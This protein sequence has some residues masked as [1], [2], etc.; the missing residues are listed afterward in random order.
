MRRRASKY[1]V[2]TAETDFPKGCD[3]AG[4]GLEERSRFFT[5]I[6]HI[7]PDMVYPPEECLPFFKPFARR[8]RDSRPPHV[9]I[10]TDRMFRSRIASRLSG[11]ELSR[12]DRRVSR[13][14]Y[15][16]R[17]G[18]QEKNAA[19]CFVHCVQRKSAPSITLRAAPRRRRRAKRCRCPCNARSRHMSAGQSRKLVWLVLVA[20]LTLASASPL[21][22]QRSCGGWTR[23]AN[24]RIGLKTWAEVARFP[25]QG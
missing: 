25:A 8:V 17:R 21:S 7:R 24:T 5:P 13:K 9:V 11:L 23:L 6:W 20:T 3:T 1:I 4:K 10:G 16:L 15:T 19:C 14:M 2:I 12:G 22:Q 18:H